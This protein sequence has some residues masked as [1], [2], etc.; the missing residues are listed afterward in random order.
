[1][2]KAILILAATLAAFLSTG[3]V[4]DDVEIRGRVVKV[5]DGDTITILESVGSR[6]P[7]DRASPA[8]TQH[9]IRLCGIDAP[10]SHQAFGQKSKLHLS[11][12]ARGKRDVTLKRVLMRGRNAGSVVPN[13]N[14]FK[15]KS[16]LK[17]FQRRNNI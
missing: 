7:R 16:I 11:S 15:T 14:Y 12:L 10:E 1:M 8:A 9:K 4:S 2:Q 17:S 5:A 3:V 6:V 13:A